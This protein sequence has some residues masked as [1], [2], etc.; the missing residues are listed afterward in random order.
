MKIIM[1]QESLTFLNDLILRLEMDEE[2][3]MSMRVQ[4]LMKKI[5]NE[6]DGDDQDV[7]ELMTILMKGVSHKR[8]HSAL[9]RHMC[10]GV[11]GKYLEV[12]DE[13]VE[14]GFERNGAGDTEGKFR[15]KV[16]HN[17]RIKA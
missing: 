9:F 5:D 3:I 12:D 7:N 17:S 6:G 11:F 13:Q 1:E 2:V 14:E 8:D 16:R 4:E 15:V 10:I